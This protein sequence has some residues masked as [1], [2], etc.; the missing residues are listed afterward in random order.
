[1]NGR[2]AI[3]FLFACSASHATGAPIA[4]VDFS[5][6]TDIAL[7]GEDLNCILSHENEGRI[8]FRLNRQEP[9]RVVVHIDIAGT[10]G[11]ATDEFS[12]SSS[13]GSYASM[14]LAERIVADAEMNFDSLTDD[15][16]YAEHDRAEAVEGKSD[17]AFATFLAEAGG[18]SF[19]DLARHVRS[20]ERFPANRTAD[21]SVSING[22]PVKEGLEDTKYETAT[23]QYRGPCN[24][25]FPIE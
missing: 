24:L 6:A 3:A 12:V 23:F 14:T 21:V 7:S 20:T 9:E 2:I 8:A 17:P 19:T 16:Y 10:D 25:V 15:E 4:S 5:D 11:N 13:A 22:V 1:M 18:Q